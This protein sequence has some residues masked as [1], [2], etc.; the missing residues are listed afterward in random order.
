MGTLRFADLQTRRLLEDLS[1]PSGAGA[2]VRDGPEQSPSVDSCPLGGA[3]GD[4]ARAGRCPEPILDGVGDAPRGG[5]GRGMV[6]PTVG[7]PPTAA[8]PAAAPAS[9]L[10][11]M[12][13]PNGA[14]S[15]PRIRL[16]RRGVIAARKSTTQ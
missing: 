3:A 14:S 2:A 12:M 16:S 13:G 8:L 10:L 1:S 15:A 11:A 5:R 9:P 6:V 4:A 7:S